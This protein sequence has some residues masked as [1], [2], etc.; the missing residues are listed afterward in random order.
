[1]PDHP[2]PSN[3]NG[4]ATVVEYLAVMSNEMAVM[5]RGHGFDTLGY[6]LEMARLEAEN[7]RERANG[8]QRE[9]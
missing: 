6:L 4:R 8:P 3:R 2:G 7:I 9:G 5:A 1:M